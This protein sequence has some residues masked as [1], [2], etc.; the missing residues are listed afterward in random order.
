VVICFRQPGPDRLDRKPGD[1]MAK[2]KSKKAHKPAKTVVVKMYTFNPDNN[3]NYNA[4]SEEIFTLR[5][6]PSLDNF[7][8]SQF[9]YDKMLQFLRQSGCEFSDFCK[10]TFSEAVQAIRQC[11]MNGLRDMVR[12]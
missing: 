11:H 10:Y 4:T 2:S 3:E 6:V 8:P 9:A 1:I 7:L 12:S 5:L